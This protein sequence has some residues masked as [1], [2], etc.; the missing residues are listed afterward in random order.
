MDGLWQNKRLPDHVA[1]LDEVTW[2]TDEG[3]RVLNPEIVLLFKARGTGPRTTATSPAPCRC[4]ARSSAPGCATTCGP[5]GR[6]TPGWHSS[7][8]RM[9]QAS[10]APYGLGMG[11]QE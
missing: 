5:S 8:I 9:R 6:S 1:P 3:V 7:D 10:G 2:V 4:S 11:I